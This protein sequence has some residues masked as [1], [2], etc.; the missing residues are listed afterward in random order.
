LK[1]KER[2]E[3]KITILSNELKMESSKSEHYADV[4]K[5]EIDIEKLK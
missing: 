2:L 5:R 3:G 1:E 4:R